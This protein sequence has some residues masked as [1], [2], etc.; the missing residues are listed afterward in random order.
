MTGPTGV[1]RIR[2]RPSSSKSEGPEPDRTLR[3][4]RLLPGGSR[5]V[6][7]TITSSFDENAS[8]VQAIMHALGM[9]IERSAKNR[10]SLLIDLAFDFDGNAR[11]ELLIGVA[12]INLTDKLSKLS[13][14]A[15]IFEDMPTERQDLRRRLAAE[16]RL[17]ARTTLCS[18]NDAGF[19]APTD[20]GWDISAFVEQVRYTSGDY[21]EI[22]KSKVIRRRGVFESP[23]VS[24]YFGYWYSAANASDELRHLFAQYLK[25][26]RIDTVVYDD[27]AEAWLVGA[28][29]EICDENTGYT[30]LSS[31]KLLDPEVLDD[32]DGRRL[33]IIGPMLRTGTVFRGIHNGLSG[34]AGHMSWLAIMADESSAD[35][36][37]PYFHT[38]SF[39]M[40]ADAPPVDVDY[41]VPVTHDVIQSNDWRLAKAYDAKPREVQD[42][43]DP[44]A[45]PTA[46]AMWSLIDHLPIGLEDPSPRRRRP[47]R[48][49]PQLKKLEP[50]DATWLAESFLRV[51][52]EVGVERSLVIVVMPQEEPDDDDPRNGSRPLAD[53]F[54]KNLKVVTATV[55]RDDLE[56]GETPPKQLTALLESHP[57]YDVVVIDESAVSFRSLL[58]LAAMITKANHGHPP[59]LLASVVEAVTGRY[60]PPSEFRSF[61]QW[62]PVMDEE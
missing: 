41:F 43:A 1:G 61:F 37:Y 53:A 60:Q 48:A 34:V 7:D 45:A 17:R 56:A 20:A 32:L 3:A 47:I 14:I 24:R 31:D 16:P 9:D 39:A 27:N 2:I 5:E 4:A 44:W 40:T 30:L 62:Q 57:G 42:P 18:V 35:R 33:A 19:V 10:E 54:K 50:A 22:V 38:K 6:A 28:L 36:Q 49:F 58:R 25:D 11:V 13:A 29:A 23:Y 52:T 26:Y 55:N 51:A 46:T 8:D 59:R 15:V 21:L 12:L